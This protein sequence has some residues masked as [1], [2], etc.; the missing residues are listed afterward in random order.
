MIIRYAQI[1][2]VRTAN[3]PHYHP[4]RI[5]R[6]GGNDL[7]IPVQTGNHR[8]RC[9]SPHTYTPITH[10]SHP[11]NLPPPSLPHQ[12][13]LHAPLVLPTRTHPDL[14]RWAT[15]VSS[16]TKDPMRPWCLSGTSRECNGLRSVCDLWNPCPCRMSSRGRLTTTSRDPEYSRRMEVSKISEVLEQMKIR[17]R[18]SLVTPT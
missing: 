18:E 2:G 1:P 5:G 16:T 17:G 4:S 14:P 8:R 9:Y 10:L 7:A 12:T 15:P 13:P 11:P 3:L 6:D